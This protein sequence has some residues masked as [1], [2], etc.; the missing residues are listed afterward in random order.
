MKKLLFFLLALVLIFVAGL[1]YLGIFPVL[2]AYV[3][4][5]VDLG[6]TPTP[7]YVED[8]EAN[9][10][11][12][13][14]PKVALDLTL[15]D[16]DITAVMSTWESR[17]S[18]FPLRNVQVKFHPDGTGE[19]SGYLKIGTAVAMAK[20][21]GYSDADIEKGKSYIKYVAG[22]LPF[23]VKGTGGMTNNILSIN[24]SSF[25]LGRVTV[26]DSITQAASL[27]VK[28]MINR[29]LTQIGGTNIQTANFT[30]GTFHL[31]GTVPS[32]IKYD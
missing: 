32:T 12:L 29:R 30:D 15:T 6:V 17:D 7:N 2:S 3:V 22:D 16:A 20:N 18:L 24:P 26:P 13:T 27:V 5:P 19:A 31:Q 9:Y 21:L 1:T 10:K 8:L 11:D 28:D 4:H 14:S 25:K 23:Y